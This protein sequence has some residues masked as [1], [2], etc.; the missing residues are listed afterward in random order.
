V[1]TLQT[2]YGLEES[3]KLIADAQIQAN[4]FGPDMKAYL[5]ATGAGN[6]PAVILLLAMQK[7]GELRYMPEQAAAKVKELRSSGK[8][9]KLNID[10]SRVLTRLAQPAKSA[11]QLAAY[12][13]S[14][15]DDVMVGMSHMTA[16]EARRELDALDAKD[17]DLFNSDG[18]RRAKAI[19]KRQ[20]LQQQIA[21][22]KS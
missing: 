13:T 6:S 22:G 11:Q 4:A 2:R 12:N 7:R 9:S 8:F 3:A 15:G 16:A 5:A 18:P 20:A 17:S 1:S 10:M 14:G 21:G 19:K